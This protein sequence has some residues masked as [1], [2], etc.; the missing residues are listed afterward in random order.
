MD[1]VGIH[2]ADRLEANCALIL[3]LGSFEQFYAAYGVLYVIPIFSL[4][5]ELQTKMFVSYPYGQAA[6]ALIFGVSEALYYVL[7]KLAELKAVW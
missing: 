2:R 7:I 3:I 1:L 4:K 6:A 5:V